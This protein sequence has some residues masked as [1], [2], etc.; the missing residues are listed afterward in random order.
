MIAPP[1]LDIRHDGTAARF[2]LQPWERDYL[3]GRCFPNRAGAE[4]RGIALHIDDGRIEG[5]LNWWV[6]G[7]IKG[8]PVAASSHYIVLRT[9]EVVTIIA[10]QHGAWTNGDVYG[11]DRARIGHL[12]D[13]GGNL[14]NW[15]ITIE[16]ECRSWESLT[17]AQIASILWLCRDI[18]ARRPKITI[19]DIF[20]HYHV[21]SRDREHCGRYVDRIV[22]MLGDDADRR[23]EP[24]PTIT[25]GFATV[26]RFD[27]P[28]KVAVT[29]GAGVNV[30]E[31]GELSAKI[32]DAWPA[33]RE[34][35]AAGFVYGDTVAGENRWYI[36]SGTGRRLWSGA[37]NKAML[38]P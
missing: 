16:A 23:A 2:G 35:W 36:L 18:M 8:E 5:D 29:A 26:V 12:L 4:P 21:N 20:G 27:R 6:H 14:N 19:A 15:T 30:R 32:L 28:A 37:T 34:F 7:K 3:L 1:M 10:E 22:G 33:G 38:R 24:G 31:W 17:E 11:P 25:P 9:G 13:L